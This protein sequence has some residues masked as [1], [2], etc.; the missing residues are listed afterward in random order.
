MEREFSF[1]GTNL[2]VILSNAASTDYDLTGQVVWP[3]AYVL[4]SWLSSLPRSYFQNKM[5]LELGAGIGKFYIWMRKL[6]NK[7][8]C[9]TSSSTLL[10][11]SGS[12]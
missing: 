8:S 4:C 3:A 5:A 7:R 6:K 12:Y 10:Q 2:K 9:W 1:G 11:T